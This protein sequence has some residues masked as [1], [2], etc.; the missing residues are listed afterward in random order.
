M[1]GIKKPSVRL[2]RA[3]AERA[4]LEAQAS[5]D[6]AVSYLRVHPEGWD[7]DPVNFFGIETDDN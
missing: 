3:Y 2:T 1:A 6:R 7:D 4:E 5:I